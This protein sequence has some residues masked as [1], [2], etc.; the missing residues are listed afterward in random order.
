MQLASAD[1]IP[2]VRFRLTAQLTEDGDIEETMHYVVQ[3]DEDDEPVKTTIVSKHDRN[4]IQAHY[5]PARRDPAD[6]ISSGED[7]GAGVCV[8]ARFEAPLT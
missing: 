2:R 4:A 3:T 5:L 8:D 6:H 1:G 7:V